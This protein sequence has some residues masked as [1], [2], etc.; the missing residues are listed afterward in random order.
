MTFLEELQAHKG[1][2]VRIKSEL[3]WYG[4]RGPDGSPGRVCLLLDTAPDITTQPL[5]LG[6]HPLRLAA[7]TLLHGDP[8]P[9][10]NVSSV[11]AYLL[12]EDK[13]QWVC[14]CS[15]DCEII[16]ETR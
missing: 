8:N 16:D 13:L 3:Y 10:D 4:G 5:R 7:I 11:S 9:F 15:R 1:G 14:V 2:L 12:I 6:G